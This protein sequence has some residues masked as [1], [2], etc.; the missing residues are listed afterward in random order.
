MNGRMGDYKNITKEMLRDNSPLKGWN[1]IKNL[2]FLEIMYGTGQLKLFPLDETHCISQW[3]MI[4][5]RVTKLILNCCGTSTRHYKYIDLKDPTVKGE[6]RIGEILY[7]N[8]EECAI[9]YC[10][11][12]NETELVSHWRCFINL[13]G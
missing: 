10:L 8:L 4:F 3:A 12:R 11:L 13:Q 5:V 6:R 9:V 2:P 7:L 1:W